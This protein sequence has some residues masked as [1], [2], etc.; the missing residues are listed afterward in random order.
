MPLLFSDKTTFLCYSGLYVSNLVF[1]C[2]TVI[3]LKFLMKKIY[4][5]GLLFDNFLWDCRA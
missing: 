4:P 2:I 1:L 5:V 3:I